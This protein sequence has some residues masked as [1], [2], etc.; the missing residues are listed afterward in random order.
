MEIANENNIQQKLS[1]LKSHYDI[2]IIE[3]SALNYLNK[4][5]EWILFSDKILSVF[6]ANQTITLVKQQHINY[7]KSLDNKFI[8]WVLNKVTNEKVKFKKTKKKK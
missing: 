5:K 7:L 4:S 1:E 6:Q 8:G 3:A 2:I